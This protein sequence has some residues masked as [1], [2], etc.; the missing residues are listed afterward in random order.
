MPI[1]R[2][3]MVLIVVSAAG[4]LSAAPCKDAKG[5]FIKCPPVAAAP[6]ARCRNAKGAFA[7]CGSPGAKPA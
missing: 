7:K 6:A 5:K 3:L 2:A 1:A 4:S